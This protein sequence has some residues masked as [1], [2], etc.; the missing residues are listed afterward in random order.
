MTDPQPK[1]NERLFER[2][3]RQHA[4]GE[5]IFIEDEEASEVFMIVEGRVRLIKRV[6]LVE[7]DIVILKAGDIFGEAAL[8][9][10]QRHPCSAVA[11]GA[12]RILA[13]PAADFETLLRDQTEVALKLI[14]QLI[15]RLQ[16]AEERIENMMLK[17]SESKIVNTLIKLAEAAPVVDGHIFLRISPIELSSRIGLDVDSVKRGILELRDNRYIGVVDEKLEV[18]DVGALRKLYRLV[19]MKEELRRG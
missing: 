6:R 11:L 3:G 8:L 5:M 19:G 4:G 12:C 13:F 9:T 10:G 18:F 16:A 15:R 2:Y 14:G 1:G 17:D 7:R